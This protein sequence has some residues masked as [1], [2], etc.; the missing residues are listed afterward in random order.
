MPAYRIDYQPGM[1]SQQDLER[2]KRLRDE[3]VGDFIR[4]WMQGRVPAWIGGKLVSP[5][6]TPLSALMVRSH[7]R[8]MEREGL[9]P[10]GD[11]SIQPHWSRWHAKEGEEKEA[12]IA[13][14]DLNGG[15]ASLV[16]PNANRLA[17]RA[18]KGGRP[19]KADGFTITAAPDP[20]A[21][22]NWREK[23]ER[24]LAREEAERQAVREGSKDDAAEG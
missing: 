1:Y 23:R 7:A 11:G 22:L 8:R 19:R 3:D 18:N 9:L 13:V 6:G 5:V 21:G 24:R 12:G 14:I 20:D 15:R 4:Y 16:R 2:R 17:V 10:P